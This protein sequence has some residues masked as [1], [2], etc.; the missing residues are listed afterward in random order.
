VLEAA[1]ASL[2]AGP[3]TIEASG[4]VT[5]RAGVSVILLNSFSV[6]AGALLAISN[7]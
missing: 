3:Y 4:D 7:S 5:L 6:S 1:C 2:T